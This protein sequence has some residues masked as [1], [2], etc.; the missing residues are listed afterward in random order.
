MGLSKI[1]KIFFY[2]CIQE[3]L[4]SYELNKLNHF[5]QHRGFNRL[6][7]CIAV[8]LISYKLG[9]LFDI[10]IDA[11]S[12]IRGALMHDF[13]LYDWR[14]QTGRK[15]GMFHCFTHP[16]EAC[17]T[18]AEHF[19]I[20]SLEQ[21]IILR[22]M[23]PLTVVPPT[24]YEALIVSLAD[25]YCTIKEVLRSRKNFQRT[26]IIAELNSNGSKAAV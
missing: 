25:K 21:N 15:G 12:M 2:G 5:V 13:Y 19:E 6:D 26:A 11:R 8:A 14:N 23:W 20:N 18:A 10:D 22:H 1:E 17:N 3:A 9:L 24:C 7:H 4:Q 16:Q